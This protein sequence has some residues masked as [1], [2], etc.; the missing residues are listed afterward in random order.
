[1]NIIIIIIDLYSIIVPPLGRNFRGADSDIL[2]NSR[3]RKITV[4][5]CAVKAKSSVLCQLGNRK[6]IRPDMVSWLMQV[7]STTQSSLICLM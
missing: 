7:C 5:H 2:C 4:N 3:S 1:M 6:G